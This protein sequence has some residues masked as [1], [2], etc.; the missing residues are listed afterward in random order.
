MYK[1][2][3]DQRQSCGINYGIAYLKDIMR[4]GICIEMVHTAVLNYREQADVE[5]MDL[6]QNSA[7]YDQ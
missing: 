4:V 1:E 5:F 6:I 2:W 7:G 3:Y